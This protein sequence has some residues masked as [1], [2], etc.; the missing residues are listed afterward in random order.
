MECRSCIEALTAYM[1]GELDS[2]DSQQVELHVS[3]CSVCNEEFRSLRISYDLFEQLGTIEVRKDLWERVISGAAPSLPGAHA[4]PRFQRP[5]FGWL[6]YA[7]GFAVV[8]LVAVFSFNSAN[9]SEDL[10]E[11]FAR[12]LNEREALAIRNVNLLEQS[13]RSG[14]NSTMYNPFVQRIDHSIQNPF[15]QE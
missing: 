7:A 1:D 3:E 10:H 9:P 11:S 4:K 2:R 12:F 5:S 14:R 15:A 6:P 13:I 8:V